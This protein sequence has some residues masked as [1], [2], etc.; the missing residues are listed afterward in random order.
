M[1]HRYSG[2]EFHSV[3]LGAVA[4]SARGRSRKLLPE[5]LGEFRQRKTVLI[6]NNSE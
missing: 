2:G 3:G 6:Y 5:R 1:T 4:L